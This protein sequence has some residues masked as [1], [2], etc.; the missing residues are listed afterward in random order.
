MV[1]FSPRHYDYAHDSIDGIREPKHRY[2]GMWRLC[3]Y[4][5]KPR[6]AA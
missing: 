4:L 2:D 6:P 5:L 1:F 3:R